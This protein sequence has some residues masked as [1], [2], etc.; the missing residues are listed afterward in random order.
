MSNPYNIFLDPNKRNTAKPYT[1]WRIKQILRDDYN[2]SLEKVWGY[3]YRRG[4]CTS[5]RLVSLTDGSVIVKETILDHL[6][7]LLTEEGYPLKDND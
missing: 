3:K 7:I 1:F 4:K 2:I 5:Y 6:R